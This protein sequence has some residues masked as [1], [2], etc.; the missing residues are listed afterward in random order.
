MPGAWFV[1]ISKGSEEGIPAPEAE[2]PL[3]EWKNPE[4]LAP[5]ATP[6]RGHLEY[7]E[8]PAASA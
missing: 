4:P 7:T 5:E 8:V 1:L 6:E 3:I 2:V